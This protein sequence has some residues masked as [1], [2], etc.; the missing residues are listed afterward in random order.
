MHSIPYNKLVRDLIPE[1]I[2]S[3]GRKAVTQCVDLQQK[4][5]YLHEKLKEEMT[6]YL[7]SGTLEELADLLEVMHGLIDCSEYTWDDLEAVRLTKKLARGGFEKGI[8]LCE[9]LE[10]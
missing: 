2:E 10:P 7:Q 9:V 6:E 4:R 8:L 1:I 5:Y 3:S